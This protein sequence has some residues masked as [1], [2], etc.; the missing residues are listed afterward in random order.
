MFSILLQLSQS[1]DPSA[2]LD[3]GDMRGTVFRMACNV[4]FFMECYHFMTH[5]FIMFRVRLLPRKDLV[6]SRYYFLID[7][8]CVF[9]VNFLLVDQLKPIA[10]LQIIQHLFYFITWEKSELCKK[11]KFFPAPLT[12]GRTSRS[13]I[14]YF[15]KP[16]LH[17]CPNLFYCLF[18]GSEALRRHLVDL[19]NSPILPN[20]NV[21]YM[22]PEGWLD[23]D[24]LSK[25]TLYFKCLVKETTK[26]WRVSLQ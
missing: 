20:S 8:T 5:M 23:L 21:F 14:F 1:L 10:V 15:I 18:V 24:L 13:R 11:V 22:C 2:L 7:T 26:G 19:S 3:I 9:I 12:R 25:G 17:Y 4:F 6:R 16:V